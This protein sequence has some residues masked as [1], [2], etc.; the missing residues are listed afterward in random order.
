MKKRMIKVVA[1]VALSCT[2]ALSAVG[3]GV[4][5]EDTVATY[6]GEKIEMGMVNFY[7]RY[8]QAQTET[9]G[10]EPGKKDSLWSQAL[11]QGMTYE[12][13]AKSSI[14]SEIESLMILEKHAS[15]YDITLTDEE[16]SKISA[17]ADQFIADNDKETL[18]KMTADKASI[19]RILSLLTLQPKVRK[20]MVADIDT[21]VED[22]EMI[23]R[24][25]AYIFESTKTTDAD[26]NSVDLDDASKEELKNKLTQVLEKAKDSDDF[27]GAAKEVDESFTVSTGT[28]GSDDTILQ[29]EVKTALDELTAEEFAPEVIETSTGYYVVQLTTERDETATEQKKASI[30]TER[31]STKYQELMT[32]WQEEVEFKI[33]ER[34][35][36][37][38]NFVRDSFRFEVEETET[39]TESIS[40]ATEESDA[41]ENT[42]DT[43]EDKSSDTTNEE[44]TN[45]EES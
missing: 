29:T 27:E 36:S 35:W 41:T 10:S 30:L 26:N 24:G 14:M 43:Q 2:L 38:V 9:T 42:D 44:E 7:A 11:Y 15:D 31:E 37:K 28:Y 17:A 4:K 32:Q 22:E 25:Y 39:Q 16:K 19:E 23:Q 18:E 12:Q 5:G 13:Y 20:A 6:N 3:C 34:N 45:S 33:N 8:Q 1:I 21:N 40:E